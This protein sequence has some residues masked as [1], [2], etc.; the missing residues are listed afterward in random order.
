MS[1]H[2]QLSTQKFVDEAQKEEI[3]Q[4]RRDI[5]A[6]ANRSFLLLMFSVIVFLFSMYAVFQ[7]PNWL[8]AISETLEQAGI[9]TSE[10]HTSLIEVANDDLIVAK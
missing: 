5:A 7:M 9:L 2:H 6:Q 4:I 10:Q 8:P 3:K 1:K